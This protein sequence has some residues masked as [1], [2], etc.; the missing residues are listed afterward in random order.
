MEKL[1][2]SAEILK[3]LNRTAQD[4]LLVTRENKYIHKLSMSSRLIACLTRKT[5]IDK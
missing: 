3:L 2:V 5:I 1:S 4:R